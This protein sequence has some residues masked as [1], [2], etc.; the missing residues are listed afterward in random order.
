MYRRTAVPGLR[1]GIIGLLLALAVAVLA[2]PAQ[3][4]SRAPTHIVQLRP[5]VSL[6]EGRTLVRAAGVQVAG[7]L[8]IIH[9]LAASLP[10]G[11]GSELSGDP[12]VAGLTIYAGVRSSNLPDMSSGSACHRRTRTPSWHRGPGRTPPAEVSASRSSTRG[13]TAASP[14]SGT[15]GRVPRRGLRGD[16]SGREDG[17]RR[18][19]HGTHVAGIIAGNGSNRTASDPLAGQY[20]GIAPEADLISVK[21]GDDDGNATVLD[22]IYGLQFAVE[23]KDA[24]NIRVSTSRSSRRSRS[25]TARTRW[26]PRW[27]RPTSTGSSSWPPRATMAGRRRRPT[28]PPATIRS[29]SPWAPSTTRRPRIAPTMRTR[30]GRASA[31]RR[32]ASRSP[33]SQPPGRRSSPRS[34]AA[35][36]SRACAR[37]ASSN[38]ST[39]GPAEPRWRRRSSPESRRSSSSAI[40]NGRRTRSRARSSQPPG[41]STAAW[42]GQRER[43]GRSGHSGAGH[44]CAQ[45]P[46]RAGRRRDRRDRLHALELEPFELE[47]GAR[48]PDRRVGTFELELRV[49]PVRSDE[50]DP[51]RSSWSRSSWSRSSWSRS[52]WSTHWSL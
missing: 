24:Y 4:A 49:L 30:N 44:D 3:A 33:R 38:A 43:G 42:G 52:S 41:T 23:H 5:D 37:I 11:A 46:E 14:T 1:T 17:G 47:H 50:V 15:P 22:V 51:T 7:A 32:T 10:A 48:A 25:P 40:P 31:R 28:S 20:M 18:F 34:Q 9:G 12:A 39:S 2:A 19:G 8:P 26:M 6:Y 45:G 13:S 35:A 29:R 16:E 21:V 27:S 36:T